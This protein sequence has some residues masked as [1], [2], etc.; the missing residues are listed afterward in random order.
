M[1]EVTFELRLEQE[2][3]I[4]EKMGV[5]NIL[6]RINSNSKDQDGNNLANFKNS[7]KANKV[8]A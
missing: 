5:K 4:P 7:M 3:P 1:K 8:G 2:G 6:N